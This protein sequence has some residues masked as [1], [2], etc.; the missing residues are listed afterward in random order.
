MLLL[1]DTQTLQDG[2]T[3]ASRDPA[4]DNYGIDRFW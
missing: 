4:F 2:L 3:L 1:L